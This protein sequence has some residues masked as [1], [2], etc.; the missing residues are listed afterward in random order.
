MPGSK[1][2]VGW[3]VRLGKAGRAAERSP[4]GGR[5]MV[6]M[7]LKAQICCLPPFRCHVYNLLVLFPWLM[8]LISPCPSFCICTVERSKPT[9]MGLVGMKYVNVYKA[10]RTWCGSWQLLN[11]CYLLWLLVMEGGADGCQLKSCG[12][13]LPTSAAC[14]C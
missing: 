11:E 9:L 8:S 14:L 13:P 12:G 4:R 1:T 3:Q 6:G 2:R 10:W 7:G 5:L